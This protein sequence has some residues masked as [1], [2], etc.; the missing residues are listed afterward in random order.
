[1]IRY[2]YSADNLYPD[3]LGGFF[4][5]WAD[6]PS[7]ETHLKLLRSSD[8]IVLA[9]D[10]DSDKVVGFIT[11][12]T[13]HIMSAY[14]PFLEVLPEYRRRGIGSELVR[15]LLKRLDKLYMIDLLCDEGLQ[16]FYS[17]L[18]MRPAN[19]MMIRNYHLQSGTGAG[20]EDHAG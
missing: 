7:A 6:G 8:E 20:V 15:Q 10:E 18:G 5:G 16:Q 3:Q 4:E 12:I 2:L 17:A 19:G 9:I 13:D 1:M 11:A 14:I